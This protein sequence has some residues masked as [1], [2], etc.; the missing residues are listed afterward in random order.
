MLS[1]AMGMSTTYEW[2]TP[3][4]V[5]GPLDLELGKFSLDVAASRRNAKASGYFTKKEDGLVQTW[6]GRVWMNPPYGRVIGQWIR[7]AYESVKNGD[8]EIVVCLIPARTD[9]GWWHD[10][11]QGKA[12][13]RFLRGRVQF[14]RPGKKL[15]NA[16]FPCAVVIYRCVGCLKGYEVEQA[17][18]LLPGGAGRVGCRSVVAQKAD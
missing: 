3:D 17:Y 2:E 11:V 8:A 1:K 13:V 12:E 18:H 6:T 14:I 7:K 16:P 5:Y 9:T 10:Y 15:D 4:E